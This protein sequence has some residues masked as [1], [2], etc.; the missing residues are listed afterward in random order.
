MNYQRTFRIF[1]VIFFAATVFGLTV[2]AVYAES[3]PQHAYRFL[4]YKQYYIP[5]DTELPIFVDEAIEY[6]EANKGYVPAGGTADFDTWKTAY[7]FD[8]P[9]GSVRA[10]YYNGAD[11]GLTRDMN[12]RDNYDEN[13]DTGNI[14]CYVSNHGLT[15]GGPQ[16][17]GLS[18]GINDLNTIA[19]VAMAWESSN[20]T[21]SPSTDTSVQFYVFD[22]E[23]A[24]IT[25]LPLDNEGPKPVPH[26]CLACHGGTYNEDDNTVNG[27]QFLPWDPYTYDFSDADGWRLEEQQESFRQMNEMVTQTNA[28]DA[29]KEFINGS[30]PQAGGVSQPGNVMTEDYIPTGWTSTPEDIQLYNEVV[31]HNCRICHVAQTPDFRSRTD[32]ST[33]APLEGFYMPHAEVTFKNFWRSTEPALLARLTETGFVVTRLDDPT[34]NG[35][36]PGDCSLR[37]AI[38]AAN[39]A[40]SGASPSYITFEAEG[41]FIMERAGID[42]NAASTGD[43]DLTN[44]GRPIYIL[45]NGFDKTIISA[46]NLDRIFDID[47]NVEAR[48]Q[49]LSLTNGA[50]TNPNIGGAVYNLGE[51]QLLDSAIYNNSAPSGAGVYNIFGGKAEIVRSTIRNNDATDS[52]GGVTNWAATLDIEDST[53]TANTATWGA[54]V[55]SGGAGGVVTT[56]YTTIANNVGTIGAGVYTFADGQLRTKATLIGD[57]TTTA[58]APNDCNG[59]IDALRGNLIESTTN[60]TINN[61]FFNRNG[62]D[63]MLEP[64]SFV[65]G[66]TGVLPLA[67]NS[68]A[69]D[70]VYINT[71]DCVSADRDQRDVIR[72]ARTLCDI[73]AYEKVECDRDAFGYELCPIVFDFE[74]ISA[75]GTP[76][77]LGNNDSVKVALPFTMPFYGEFFSEAYVGSNGLLTFGAGS[78]SNAK[79]RLP[80]PSAPANM[81]AAWWTDLDPSLGGSIHT[82]Q[83]GDRFIVQFTDVPIAGAVLID[84]ERA[85]F[86]LQLFSNGDIELH[87]KSTAT[88][89]YS[90]TI[91]LQNADGESGATFYDNTHSAY[92]GKSQRGLRFTYSPHRAHVNENIDDKLAAY[93]PMDAGTGSTFFDMS[94]NGND[95]V[96]GNGQAGNW[97]SDSPAGLMQFVGFNSAEFDGLNDYHVVQDDPT[98]DIEDALTIAAWINIDTSVNDQKLISK[99]SLPSNEGFV[100]GV[101]DGQLYPEVFDA[102]GDRYSF[103]AGLIPDQA[104]THVAVTYLP[105]GEM[106]GYINGD[107]IYAIDAGTQPIGTNDLDL[108]IGAASWDNTFF[109]AK[110]ALDQVR[111]YERALSAEEIGRLA[112]GFRCETTGA[113]WTTAHNDLNCATDFVDGFK[114]GNS[115]VTDIYVAGGTYIAGANRQSSFY[116]DKN[117][118][119]IY[120]GYAGSADN[121]RDI[122]ANPTI[123]SGDID[124]N[125]NGGMQSGHGLQKILLNL[126]N[127]VLIDGVTIEGADA[128]NAFANDGGG[129]SNVGT[130]T[131]ANSIVQNNQAEN[132][133]GFSSG[134]GSLTISNTLVTSNTAQFDG[135]GIHIDVGSDLDLVASAINANRADRNGGGVAVAQFSD[136]NITIDRSSMM[137][138][139]AKKGGAVHMLAGSLHSTN[140]SYLDNIL[141][142]PF[143][144]TARG[145]EVVTDLEGRGLFL[146]D[147][148]HT[149]IYSTIS[150][151]YS[152]AGQGL[153]GVHMVNATL[154]TTASIFDD[155]CVLDANS[156]VTSGGYNIDNASGC[157]FVLPSTIGDQA[158]TFVDLL[159][160]KTGTLTTWRV[161]GPLL[162]DRVPDGVAGCGTTV[163]VDQRGAPRPAGSPGGAVGCDVGAGEWSST[164]PTAVA[165]SSNAANI[166]S[167]NR[168]AMVAMFMMAITTYVYISKRSTT[169]VD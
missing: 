80:S 43:Y 6:L 40:G 62:V 38:I 158:A 59:T 127:N 112:D 26:L 25:Q 39:A 147:G 155:S 65:N 14:A 110:G 44:T 17:I 28:R 13:A 41:T 49:H 122:A 148:S 50:V 56:T 94:V 33:N 51:L 7:G 45:G 87:H 24:P 85:T 27:A 121:A 95:A 134:S 47:E 89:L 52:G 67:T 151:R 117:D 140:S 73:G 8:N 30:Y 143:A 48:I 108:H 42:E 72:P 11:L 102:N 9:N 90:A 165:L 124:R 162:R 35:C 5:S 138:N 131:V 16:H 82:Q 98:L 61:N 71:G 149:L 111:L 23:G 63:P 58:G 133:G 97:S 125:D 64:L 101:L 126:A 139:V 168:I 32:L 76:L 96:M 37:E 75:T 130:I 22:G 129:V 81:I 141:F 116:I 74:D 159:A 100:L 137:H 132:G 68:P 93:W 144:G 103:E 142:D 57:N 83:I 135:G 77:T 169:E 99:L 53:I 91:G 167:S 166:G 105:G 54:G 66:G 104:W 161:P 88:R 157:G 2:Y 123:L 92:A 36:S 31:K 145:E 150:N 153:D 70:Q 4:L 21:N 12:C 60:C 114:D 128:R 20:A 29:I 15:P 106:V 152:E 154:T 79:E 120:G 84:E 109:R 3:F 55:T 119:S 78:S 1:S 46:E 118:V 69:I 164:V 107:R 19:T 146:Q 86:Q 113:S 34:P 160:D 115:T 10:V 163:T 156:Q 18:D 136:S